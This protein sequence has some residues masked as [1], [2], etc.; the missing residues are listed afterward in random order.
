MEK[1]SSKETREIERINTT[2][3]LKEKT[4]KEYLKLV[5]KFEWNHND[6]CRVPI[7]SVIINFCSYKFDITNFN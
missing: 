5:S 1:T 7:I 2:N 4:Y 3:S 6:D